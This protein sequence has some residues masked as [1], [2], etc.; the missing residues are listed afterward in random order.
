MIVM[1]TRLLEKK[2]RKAHHYWP[3]T[4]GEE[5]P[6]PVM[7]L[8]GGSRVEFL[9]TE[10]HGSFCLRRFSLWLPDGGIR[11]VVQLHTEEWPDLEAPEDPR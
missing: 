8:E 9:T 7:A 11:E 5:S 3:D 1:I 4:E 10:D 6:G 2:K